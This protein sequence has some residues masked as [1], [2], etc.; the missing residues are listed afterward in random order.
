[1]KHFL[2]PRIVI[3]KCIEHDACRYNGQMI[4]SDFVKQLKSFVEFIPVCPEYEIGLG[5]PRDPIRIVSFDGNLKLLQPKTEKDVTKD[6]IEFSNSFLQKVKD[7][8][9]FILKSKSPSCGI[10]DVKIHA[11]AGPPPKESKDS[12]FFGKAVLG[13]YS[14]I[15]IEDEG[16]LINSRIKQHF[17]TKVY[18]LRKFRE[19]KN[20]MLKKD[21]VEYQSYNKLL[22]GAYS[23][24]ETKELGRIVANMDKYPLEK[25]FQNYEGHLYALFSKPPKCSPNINILLHG[26][27]YISKNL[28]KKEKEFFFETIDKYRAGKVSLSVPTNILKSWVLRFDEKYLENQSFFEP[29]PSELLSVEDINACEVRDYW[30]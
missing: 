9:G 28:N 19:V 17:L 16:R 27:G 21:L 6:M 23:Q 10:K 20:S 18:A 29:Y 25:I 3:S 2:K 15:A 12:G 4:S 13:R 1:M 30:E 24:K 22:F 7:I 26:F 11:G 14:N 5:V 8:D